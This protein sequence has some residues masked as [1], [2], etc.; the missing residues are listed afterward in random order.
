MGVGKGAI[1]STV[2]GIKNGFFELAQ[3]PLVQHGLGALKAV[4]LGAR[5]AALIAGL[6]NPLVAAAGL[7]YYSCWRCGQ[8]S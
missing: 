2:M 4:N 6:S 8:G 3:A 1:G 5:G 7:S